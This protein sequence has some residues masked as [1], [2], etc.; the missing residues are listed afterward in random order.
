MYAQAEI[1]LEADP[2]YDALDRETGRAQ[3]ATAHLMAGRIAHHESRLILTRTVCSTDS[4]AEASGIRRTRLF[5]PTGHC[6]ITDRRETVDSRLRPVEDR[7]LRRA[8][9]FPHDD[10]FELAYEGRSGGGQ[11]RQT[12]IR[13]LIWIVIRAFRQRPIDGRQ[14]WIGRSGVGWFDLG[15]LEGFG[16]VHDLFVVKRGDVLVGEAE[17]GRQDLGGVL[18]D[19]WGPSP[20]L[21]GCQGE[22]GDDAVDVDGDA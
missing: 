16:S 9:R 20:D 12:N 2:S 13:A 7:R 15:S 19:R 4:G 3:E 11:P 1:E 18:T 14:A 17:H 6:I 21:S 10:R 8:R 22:F 5:R